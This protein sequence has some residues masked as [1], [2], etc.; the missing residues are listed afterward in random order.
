[1]RSKKTAATPTPNP[2]NPKIGSRVR[3]TDDGIEGRIVWA[4]AVSV[5]IRWQDGEQVTWRRDALADRPIEILAAGGDE[6]PSAASVAA[7]A[8]AA[9]AP[10]EPSPKESETASSVGQ[11]V[12]SAEQP[13]TEAPAE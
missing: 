5:K 2:Q 1:M 12:L 4:N 6:A 8:N 13:E 3:C 11:D 7:D 9:T 10:R